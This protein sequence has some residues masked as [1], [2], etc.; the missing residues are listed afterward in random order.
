MLLN[1]IERAMMNNPIRAAVQRRFEGP[2][3]RRMGGP[4]PGARVLEVGCG[5]G[6]GTEIVLRQFGA[7]RVDAF[8]LDPAM[9][10]LARRRLASHGD[11]VRIWTGDVTSI[12]AD[13]GTYD[14]VFDF[15]IIH[16][17]PRWR[18]AVA[19]I[20]RVLA[21]G[22][23]LYAEEVLAPFLASPLWSRVLEHPKDDRFD[24][25]QFERALVDAGLVV[26][27]TEALWR[28]FAWFVAH[29]E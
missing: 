25:R 23:R 6:V 14:A 28:R 1:A 15:G 7:A 12:D 2:R 10:A 29:K 17:V 4:L 22:G 9:V 26:D 21:P 18:D 19:E 8:D 24:A 5:R 13:S 11:R 3:L 20:A 16:H 27:A